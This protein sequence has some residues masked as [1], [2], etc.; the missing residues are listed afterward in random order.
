MSITKNYTLSQVHV[1]INLLGWV[2]MAIGGL[3]YD[4]YATAARTLGKWHFWLHNFGVPIMMGG[5]VGLESGYTSFTPVVAVGSS[6]ILLG[7]L[8]FFINLVKNVHAG[9]GSH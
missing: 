7:T 8:V 5:L 6:L 1:H 3:V 4:R 2:S 9:Q